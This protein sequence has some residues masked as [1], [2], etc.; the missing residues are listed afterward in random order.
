MSEFHYNQEFAAKSYH[1]LR[2]IL[3][4]DM[5]YKRKHNNR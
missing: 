2:F 3:K 5:F 1:F 4:I